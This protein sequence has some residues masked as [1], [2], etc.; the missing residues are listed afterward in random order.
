MDGWSSELLLYCCL[1]LILYFAGCLLRMQ[2]D[3]K[4]FSI[5]ALSFFKYL[6]FRNV[7]KSAKSKLSQKNLPKF[8]C[9]AVRLFFRKVKKKSEPI[10]V[11]IIGGIFFKFSADKIIYF[12]WRRDRRAKEN[13]KPTNLLVATAEHRLLLDFSERDK[14]YDQPQWWPPPALPG[15]GNLQ[16]TSRHQEEAGEALQ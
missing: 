5:P 2:C 3:D 15:S 14:D 4:N 13:I 16:Q 8:D 12:E 10:L 7:I 11:H 1:Q 9:S 6:F